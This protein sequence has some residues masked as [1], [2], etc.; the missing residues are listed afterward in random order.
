MHPGRRSFILKSLSLA[1]STILLRQY[2]IAEDEDTMTEAESL[3]DSA[4]DRSSE[5]LRELADPQSLES[6][7]LTYD[8]R[9]SSHH[10]VGLRSRA[11]VR[12]ERTCRDTYT[13][14]LRVR[15]PEGDGLVDMLVMFA[16]GK[17]TKEYREVRKSVS[18]LFSEEMRFDGRFHTDRFIM[19]PDRDINPEMP[20][21]YIY[22]DRG[23][24][25]I[26][27]WTSHAPDRRFVRPYNGQVCALTGFWNYVFF[28]PPKGGMQI[29]NIAKR[30]GAEA[31]FAGFTFEDI[32]FREDGQYTD[33][34]YSGD[35]LLDLICGKVEYKPGR[36]RG[37]NLPY[38]VKA[39]GIVNKD[40]PKHA[41]RPVRS[42]RNLRAYL[43]EVKA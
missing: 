9:M 29:V 30:R 43:S 5:F 26:S 10:I 42:A 11:D 31:P 23:S 34:L 33:L 20:E 28:G 17:R 32:Y 19:K 24:E 6:L 13:T 22:F 4:R 27:S 36:D 21:Q 15:P 38:L 25:K 14:S 16:F 35:A 39:G 8:L 37:K 1:L 12:L 7:A 3:E 2:A 41:G 40:Q 18:K